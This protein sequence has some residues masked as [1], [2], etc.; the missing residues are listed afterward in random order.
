MSTN[1][2]WLGPLAA[3]IAICAWG[4]DDGSGSDDAAT[5]PDTADA[6]DAADTSHDAADVET[7]PGE[8]PSGP[9]GTTESSIIANLEFTTADGATLDLAALRDDPAVELLLVYGTAGWCTACVYESTDLPGIYATYHGQGLEVLAAVFE[10]DS[11]APATVAYAAGYR[12]YYGFEFPTVAD[13]DLQ[14]CDYFDKSQAPLNMF[15]DLDTMEIL[16]IG[17]G[18]VSG[19]APLESAIETHL[20]AV[21]G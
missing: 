11:A 17:V 12:D 21:S 9:Y 7:E 5:D 3:A 6:A 15:I 19:G 20:A 14:T 18:Y 1:G 13:T 16:E 8:Y 10:D 2:K 4:C